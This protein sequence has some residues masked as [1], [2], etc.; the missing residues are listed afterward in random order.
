MYLHIHTTGCLDLRVKLAGKELLLD[1][2]WNDPPHYLR[3]EEG[4]GK[5]KEEER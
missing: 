5:A 2:G 1:G 3:R 4:K